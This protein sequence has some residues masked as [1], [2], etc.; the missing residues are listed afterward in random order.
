MLN[1]LRCKTVT[2]NNQDSAVKQPFNRRQVRSLILHVLY[3]LEAYDDQ[4]SI[5][6][7]VT[8][9]NRGYDINIPLDGEIVATAREIAE[10]KDAIDEQML[11]FLKGWKLDRLGLCTKIILRMGIWELFNTYTPGHIVINEA[12]ELAQGFSEKDA[13]KFV[14]GVLDQAF[15]QRQSSVLE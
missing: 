13:Y 7:V 8:M 4:V 9:L 1:D 15:K 6:S 10:K 11:P 14:N 2:E 3:A 12:I 5:E